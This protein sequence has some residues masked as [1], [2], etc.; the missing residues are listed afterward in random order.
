MSESV[1]E[2]IEHGEG[3]MP[4][5][6]SRG[7]ALKELVQKTN[8]IHIFKKG[9]LIMWPLLLVSV[10]ALG[11]T[12]ERV[13]FL[14]AERMRRNPKALEDFFAAV[15]KGDVET[16][17]RVSD[18]SRFFVV[19]ALGYALV[20]KDK[21]LTNGLLYGQQR[22]LK[23]YKRGIPILDTCITLAPLLGLLGTVT[24]MMGSFSV[25][26]GDLSS[27]GAITGGIAE[28]L[29]ATAFGLVIAITGVI[30]F[31]MLNA[32]M[33]EARGELEAASTQLELLMHPPATAIEAVNM[34]MHPVHASV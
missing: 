23:R 24:G 34:A 11:A 4:L 21:S 28:A 14:G 5:D 8:L 12:I 30:P 22:E 16:A 10:L 32:R 13:I 9:G 2:L 25:I 17:I 3:D 29:I 27:P 15:E 26:G 20:Q 6:P 18:R 19:R 7:G 31:N 33:E 1:S